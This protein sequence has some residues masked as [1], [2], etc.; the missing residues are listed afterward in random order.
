MFLPRF[1]YF[2]LL[3]SLFLRGD[4]HPPCPPRGLP[5]TSCHG[6]VLMSR[7][8]HGSERVIEFLILGCHACRPGFVTGLSQLSRICHVKVPH[9][10][11]TVPPA[12]LCLRYRTVPPIRCASHTGAHLSPGR[13][14]TPTSTR[15]RR[16]GARNKSDFTK[17]SSCT[18]TVSEV[19]HNGARQRQRTSSDTTQ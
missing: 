14:A 9:F 16:R 7:E 18:T 12:L 4:G 2:V 15:I 1:P 10:R 19:P 8:S 13:T 6:L 17:C 5:T 3:P 11:P